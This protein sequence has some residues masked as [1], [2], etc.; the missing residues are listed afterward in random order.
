MA[1]M[2]EL[3]REPRD[4]PVLQIGRELLMP[5]TGCCLAQY[6]KWRFYAESLIEKSISILDAVDGDADLKDGGDGEPS[7]ASSVGGDS[8]LCWSA[9]SD[10]DR[11]QP[12]QVAACAN[13]QP[14][15][16]AFLSRAVGSGRPV[17]R[18]RP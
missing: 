16:G 13:K 12:V 1:R 2:D 15:A 4:R 9:G 10:D 3:L 17:S 8:Q 6:R 7:L 14:L 11:E 18:P 5:T